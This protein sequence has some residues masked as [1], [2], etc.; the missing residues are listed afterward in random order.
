V[1]PFRGRTAIVLTAVTG[2][3][4]LALLL[5]SV[6]GRELVPAR[7]SEADSFSRSALGH[8]AFVELL[9]ELEVPTVVSRFN[10]GAKARDSALLVV[11][12][13]RVGR[14]DARHRMLLGM[15]A[16]AERTLLVLP[17]W[18]GKES[19]E[20]PGFIQSAELLE[21]WE[22]EAVLDAID[23]DV[24]LVRVPPGEPVSWRSGEIG[25]T[26]DIRA[27]QL[28]RGRVSGASVRC[29]QGVLLGRIQTRRGSVFVLSDPDLLSNHGLVRPGNALAVMG[30]LD[31]ARGEQDAV[32]IDETLH[33]FGKEPSLFRS[34]F[35]FPLGLATIQA[36]FAAAVLLW[37][38][39]GRF[40]APQ[41][42]APP[43]EA[44][45]KALIGNIAALLAY[46]GHGAHAL[47]RYLDGS[48]AEVRAALHVPAGLK[49]AEAEERLDRAH[50]A[51]RLRELRA[52][53]TKETKDRRR[54]LAIARRIHR[55]REE[56]IRG[57]VGHP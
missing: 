49:A 52:L 13:P 34:L 57:R 54:I 50:G 46:G 6:F 17:K 44:G 27:P 18:R 53:A 14:N 19:E 40:G 55:W 4:F 42:A 23:A 16:Q 11:A 33:G 12:E 3:S 25:A 45:K 47:R 41:P 48:V 9:K 29:A 10:S 39:M 8:L 36:L 37:G 51:I 20:Q 5:W 43:F 30:M 21:Q 15:I 2:V 22:V 31:L 1:N 26:P 56:T 35:E 24:E 38:A 7:S 32:V 28:L